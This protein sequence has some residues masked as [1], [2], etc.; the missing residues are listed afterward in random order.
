MTTTKRFTVRYYEIGDRRL[1]IRW[2]NDETTEKEDWKKN[3]FLNKLR[4]EREEGKELFPVP[5]TE[6]VGRAEGGERPHDMHRQTQSR[7]RV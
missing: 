7:A 6:R 5:D 4:G 1:T 3:E 2:C